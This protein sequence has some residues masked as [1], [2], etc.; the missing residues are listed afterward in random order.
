[1]GMDPEDA[2]VWKERT[3]GIGGA[4]GPQLEAYVQE[5]DG[6]IKALTGQLRKSRLQTFRERVRKAVREG[7]HRLVTGW[8]GEEA[9][10][11]ISVVLTGAGQHLVQPMQVAEAFATE[12]GALWR[13]PPEEGRRSPP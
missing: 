1:M 2:E 8:V 9:A 6:R 4:T 12:W 13:P 3:W 5:L 10:P 7:K 11:P